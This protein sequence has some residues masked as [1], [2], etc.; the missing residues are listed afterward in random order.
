MNATGRRPLKPV[1]LTVKGS[2]VPKDS[3]SHAAANCEKYEGILFDNPVVGYTDSHRS[4]FG[5][6]MG[7]IR[8]LAQNRTI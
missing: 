7:D 5:P 6:E 1:P 3:K 2:K 8:H 4:I